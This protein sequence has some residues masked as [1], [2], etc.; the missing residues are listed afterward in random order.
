M[1]VLFSSNIN[2]NFKTFSDYIEKAFIEAGCETYFF[3]NRDFVIPGRI[4]D[5]VVL[6]QEWDLRR[7]NKRLLEKA[8]EFKPQ[9]Y[10]E[11]GGWNILPDTI[12]I[13]K[14]MGIKTV[15]W[16]VDPPHTFKA[17]IKAVPH[18]DFVFCQGTEA[19]QILKEYDVKNLHWLPFA[20]DPDYHKPVELAPS[21]RKKY[22]TE[23]CFVGSWNPASN[24]QNYAKRQA[25]LECL[26][27]YD[28]GIWGPGWNNLPVESSLKKFVRGLH[29]KPEEWVKIYSAT[30]ITV[31]VHYQ[32][33]KG[34]VPCYQ[35][36]PKVFEA[37]ACGAL[38][39]VDDQR[40]IS[41]L[42]EPGKHLVVY[43]NHKELGEIISYYL[44]HPD[45]ARKIAQQGRGN[46]LENHTFKHR[47]K[48]MLG[49]IKKG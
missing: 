34:H 2:P 16:T 23:I 26:T 44:E 12:D 36:S 45:E 25:A 18:Y 8:A 22:G 40:D 7:L 21:E 10:V 6:L 49:I 4:R 3:E 20:C 9:I 14:S 39:V 30:R 46:V 38:L 5:R 35:A 37:M 17:I 42:F 29:T 11:A 28:L 41:S 33:T 15:L 32:D 31:I 1:K 24:L 43:H 47:V 48:E 27:N 13:L 19:I